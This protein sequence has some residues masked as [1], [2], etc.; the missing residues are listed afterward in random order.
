MMWLLRHFGEHIS[1]AQSH[2]IHMK[3]ES[4]FCADQL[5]VKKC[6]LAVALSLIESRPSTIDG[7][8]KRFQCCIFLCIIRTEIELFSSGKFVWDFG[9]LQCGSPSLDSI[10]RYGNTHVQLDYLLSDP[11]YT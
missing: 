3:G 10:T 2:S 1:A 7:M 4:L 11:T 9:L 6:H 8:D 5:S